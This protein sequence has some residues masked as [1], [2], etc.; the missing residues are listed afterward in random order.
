MPFLRVNF[1]KFSRQAGFTLIELLVVISIIA[2]LISILLPALRRARE[3]AKQTMCLANLRSV[4]G[5][6]LAYEVDENRLPLHLSE[7]PGLAS[8]NADAV[9]LRNRTEDVRQLMK[10]YVAA[11]FYHCGQLPFWD[12]GVGALPANAG[13]NVY[14]DF[15]IFPGRWANYRN[16]AYETQ[17]WVRSQD[18]LMF[19][20]RKLRVIASDR[21]TFESTART[22]VNHIEGLQGFTYVERTQLGDPGN[23][24]SAYYIDLTSG[25]DL[26]SRSSANYAMAD[27]SASAYLGDDPRLIDV[28]MP[29]LV[30]SRILVPGQ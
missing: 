25:A 20:G 10:P 5:G 21:L 2:L 28:P 9:A 29:N 8:V 16:S 1:G 18:Q 22:Q 11:D 27:G 24:C 6:M 30:A 15:I 19:E 14:L 23:F 4:T 17:R 12:R 3:A 26:R 13:K 7:L